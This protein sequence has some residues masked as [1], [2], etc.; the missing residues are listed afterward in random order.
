MIDSKSDVNQ[1]GREQEPRHSGNRENTDGATAVA[2]RTKQR[3]RGNI[4]LRGAIFGPNKSGKTSLFRRLQG[5]GFTSAAGSTGIQNHCMNMKEALLQAKKAT[6]NWS[7]V[8]NVNVVNSSAV[9]LQFLDVDLSVNELEAGDRLPK[10]LFHYL[11]LMLDPRRDLPSQEEIVKQAF[12]LSLREDVAIPVCII[13]NFR[14]LMDSDH[15]VN[16]FLSELKKLLSEFNGAQVRLEL[17]DLTD[18]YAVY[19]CAGPR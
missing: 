7:P 8:D 16:I 9:K 4:V 18:F 19:N 1:E 14:D 13:L 3:A 10:G 12:F 5:G 15:A 17:S 11:I 2:L 6:I